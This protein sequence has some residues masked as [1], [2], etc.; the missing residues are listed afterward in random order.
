M[1]YTPV[2]EDEIPQRNNGGNGR[3]NWQEYADVLKS[4]PGTW[5]ELSDHGMTI[6]TL[7]VYGG[8]IRAGFLMAFRPKGA[9]EAKT[10]G[11]RLWARYVGADGQGVAAP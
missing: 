1:D 2:T 10:R 4:D 9:F 5:Y 11:D 8:R 6:P 7:R 3:R